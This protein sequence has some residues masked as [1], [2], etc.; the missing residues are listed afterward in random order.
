MVL[1]TELYK[2]LEKGFPYKFVKCRTQQSASVRERN[3]CSLVGRK[4][5]V[6]LS[7]YPKLRHLTF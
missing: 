4:G 5:N 7:L 6:I 2:T 1:Q 3:T